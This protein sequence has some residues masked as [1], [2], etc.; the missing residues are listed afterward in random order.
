MRWAEVDLATGTVAVIRAV[1]HD[2]DTETLKSRRIL[3]LPQIAVDAL[4]QILAIQARDRLIAGEAWQEHGLV[5]RTSV[6]TPPD[7][8]NVR[9]E[10]RKVA[11]AAGLSTGWAPRDLRHTFV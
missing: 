2:G 3:K 4:R 6:G 9:R 5:F 1:R 8:A 10:F 7:D 11:M